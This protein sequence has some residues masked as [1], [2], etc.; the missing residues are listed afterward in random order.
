MRQSY[1]DIKVVDLKKNLGLAVASNKGFEIAKGKYL[2][3][4]NNDTIADREL[5]S[6]LVNA[7]ENDPAIGVAGCLTY[8]YKGE[9]LINA[10]VP[11]DIFGYPYGKHEPFYVDA[12]IFIPKDLFGAIGGFDEKM[13]LYGE[14]RDLCWRVWLYGR[15]VK[16]VKNAR[17]FHDSACITEDISK[18]Q[19]NIRKRFLGEFNALRSI[20]KNYGLGLI[21][22][23][24]AY[25]MINLAEVVA[26]LLK[27]DFKVVRYAYIASYLD[28][29][30]DIKGLMF[31]RKRV[32]AQR[33]ISD[34][35][36]VGHMDKIPGKLRLLLDMGLPRFSQQ[37][38][39]AIPSSTCAK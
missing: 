13:F 37:N 31:L 25:I 15:K 23:L 18:Y 28:N 11:C 2:L 22:I 8:T 16:V 12:S 39:Y 26:F 38:K 1:K 20:L 5:V 29:L 36:L 35:E 17:F 32:Q 27:G 9:K 19:T 24:P 3:F 30:R 21:F 33:K 4:Y 6:S 10:G 7:C 34:F 14:D